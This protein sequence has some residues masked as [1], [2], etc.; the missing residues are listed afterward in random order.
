MRSTRRLCV[1]VLIL[2][3]RWMDRSPDLQQAVGE[4]MLFSTTP[5]AKYVP[6]W[7][8]KATAE[9]KEYRRQWECTTTAKYDEWLQSK[10]ISMAE[11][12]VLGREQ[13]CAR[14]QEQAQEEQSGDVWPGRKIVHP[15]PQDLAAKAERKRVCA[16]RSASKPNTKPERS[17]WEEEDCRHDFPENVLRSSRVIT[18]M[19]GCC[20][21]VGLELLRDT[22]SPAH[23]VA[24]LVQRFEK[25]P[26]VVHFKI[27]C[28]AQRNALRRVPWLSE[29]SEMASFVDRF[30]RV[31]HNCS[32]VFNADQYPA[33]TR[34]HDTSSS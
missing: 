19:C 26:R 18:F 25:L 28:Q 14:L 11:T 33:L 20:C 30:H 29:L 22:E 13:S 32:A 27:A 8:S 21:I 17:A 4:L 9:A 15:Y 16:K 23:V 1:G 34:G 3:R 10:G 12:H 5:E 24:A 7:E 6:L 2:P 31:N